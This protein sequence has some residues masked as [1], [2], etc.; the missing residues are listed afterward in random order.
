MC[1]HVGLPVLHGQV[2][3]HKLSDES[4]YNA[5]AR[6]QHEEFPVGEHLDALIEEAL[7]A[8]GKDFRFAESMARDAAKVAPRHRRDS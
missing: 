7:D 6:A 5:A 2:S 4:A 8:F 3:T 1:V